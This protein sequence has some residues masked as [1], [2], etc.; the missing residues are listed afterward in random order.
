ME[1]GRIGESAG[2]EK[3]SPLL[4]STVLPSSPLLPSPILCLSFPWA[5]LALCHAVSVS[6]SPLSLIRWLSSFNMHFDGSLVHRSC[7]CPIYLPLPHLPA[8]FLQVSFGTPVRSSLIT[9]TDGGVAGWQAPR[10][11]CQPSHKP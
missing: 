5:S 10:C 11:S 7:I 3:H 8:S 2:I 6:S 4:S 1:T 9:N